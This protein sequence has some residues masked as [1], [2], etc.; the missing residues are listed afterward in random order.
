[1]VLSPPP[2]FQHLPS[3]SAQLPVQSHPPPPT[4]T[5][6]HEAEG[7]PLFATGTPSYSW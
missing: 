2:A 3:P 7:N 6:P 1:M 4:T 5:I